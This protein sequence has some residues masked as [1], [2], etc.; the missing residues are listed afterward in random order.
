MSQSITF[1]A[2]F[3]KNTSDFTVENPSNIAEIMSKYDE[4]GFVVIKNILSTDECREAEDL[5]YEDLMSSIDT[6]LIKDDGLRKVYQNVKNCTEHFPKD[7]LPGLASKGFLSLYGFPQGKFAWKLRTNPIVK[8]I[9]AGLHECKEDDLCVSLD[10]PFFTPDSYSRDDC[11][12]WS[13][14]DQNIHEKIGSPDSHQGILY[15]WDSTKH[16]TS[17]TVVI[18]KSHKKEYFELLAAIPE[19]SYDAHNGIYI[20]SIPD[21]K[22]KERLLKV[23]CEQSR[24]IPV[25]S[26]ALLIFNSRTIHQ[27]Y[28][29]GLRLAQ[30]IC[31][32]PKF[33]RSEQALIKK[34]QAC[35]MGIATTHWASLGIHHGV[36]FIKSKP[37]KYVGTGKFHHR[38]IFPLKNI[39]L[40]PLT[41]EAKIYE[42]I[43][44]RPTRPLELPLSELMGKIKPEYRQLL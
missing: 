31:W 29:N 32:E 42:S 40:V 25:P 18:P 39:T 34:A 30:T 10:V 27:G 16:G 26:G 7:S 36:S 1:K 3:L 8:S 24:R 38:N 17:N 9:Y 41:I 37:P 15:V 43:N 5:M 21:V 44:K 35:I 20:T 11:S 19:H 4:W 33:Y 22:E 28:Q 23:W 13:H 6:D 12:V 14:A 2:P